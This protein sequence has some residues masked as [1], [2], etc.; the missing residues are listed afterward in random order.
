MPEN[1]AEASSTREET[2]EA[3]PLHCGDCQAAFAVPPA[4]SLSGAAAQEAGDFYCPACAKELSAALICE[5]CGSA[6]CSTCGTP[7]ELA[8]ELGIG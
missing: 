1:P 4:G 3:T 2:T 6:I 7:V 5:A 8:D